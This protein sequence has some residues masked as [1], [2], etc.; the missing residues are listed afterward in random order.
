MTAKS[1]LKPSAESLRRQEETLANAEIELALRDARV[2]G[3]ESQLAVQLRLLNERAQWIETRVADVRAWVDRG[4]VDK[5]AQGDLAELLRGLGDGAAL[6][7]ADLNRYVSRSETLMVARAAMAAQRADVLQRRTEQLD[8]RDKEV[9]DCEEAAVRA[10]VRLAARERMVIEAIQRLE[11]LVGTA[12]ADEELNR[13]G[14]AKFAQT[15]TMTRRENLVQDR[16]TSA[17]RTSA[18]GKAPPVLDMSVPVT[19]GSE[20]PK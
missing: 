7:E 16:K 3:R 9:S 15:V 14:R 1:D 8:D 10:E 6:Q 19:A 12:G 18:T 13:I 11:Q 2:R 4:D 17:R 5:V 20:P